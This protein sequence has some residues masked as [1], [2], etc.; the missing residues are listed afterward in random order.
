MRCLLLVFLFFVIPHSVL[1]QG[2]AT[3]IADSVELEGDTQLIA[4]GNVEVLFGETRLSAREIQFDANSDR[5]QIVGPLFIQTEDGAVLSADRASLDPKLENGL[6]RGARL[7]LNRKLQL[8]ANQIDRVDGRYSQLFR[9]AVTSCQICSNEPPLWSIRAE[10][11]IHD[12]EE[13]QIYFENARFLVRDFPIFWLPR[14]RLPDPTLTRATGF[15]IPRIR[16]TNRLSTG[17]KIPYFFVLND[18]RDLT[19]TPYL[20]SETK[21][22]EARY[23]QAFLSGELEINA[24]ASRDQLVPGTVRNYL[25]SSGQF[26]LPYEF[27]MTFDVETASDPAY[28]VD[29][30]YLSK[31]RLDSA[32]S[33][34]RLKENSLTIGS[35]TYYETLRDSETNDTLPPFVADLKY[36]RRDNLAVG[37]TLNFLVDADLL[38]RPDDGSGPNS[39][40]VARASAD[41]E[42]ENRWI[43][44]SGLVFNGSAGL[45]TDLFVIGD[46]ASF[47]TSLMRAT[48][49]F[50]TSVRLPLIRKESGTTQTLEPIV[51]LAWSNPIGDTPPN[52][53]AT[54][55]ELDQGNLLLPDQIPGQDVGEEGFRAAFGLNYSRSTDDG[56]LS[57][58]ALG[59]V[60]RSEPNLA[61]T[62][63]SGLDG[64]ASDWMIAGEY[65]NQTGLRFEGRALLAEDFRPTLATGQLDWT[66]DRLSLAASYIWQEADAA[67]GSGTLSEWSFDTAYQASEAWKFS[68]D[69]RYDVVADGPTRAGIGV[70]WRNEC[71]IFDLSVSRR[72]TSSSTVEPSTDYGLSVAL[73]GFSA[74]RSGI[75]SFDRCN[76]N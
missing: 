75:S 8:A 56:T 36:E 51:A 59:R 23:R 71:V 37:G 6:L 19:I 3:L 20:S 30:G 64:R 68:F 31:D 54:R 69:T 33:I 2:V 40:D 5:L 50:T 52:E 32:I 1:A 34:L 42:W 48:P 16:T 73:T 7:V 58:L 12:S 18:H 41:L 43:L 72:F 35:L 57:R 55:P 29:Y 22:L 45:S 44:N 46:D 11:V 74:G 62:E 70:E 25:F 61:F 65:R 53:D 49:S 60:L 76:N 39:R 67:L 14:M 21:T 28:L 24:A 38:V 4:R 10:R 47:D 26:D 66:T 9:T 63:S 17:V 15:L 13:K 27:S